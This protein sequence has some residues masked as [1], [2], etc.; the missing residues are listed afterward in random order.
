MD[1][2]ILTICFVSGIVG[3]VIAGFLTAGAISSRKIQEA[4]KA[5]WATACR[6]YEQKRREAGC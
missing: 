3:G 6:H 4:E 2:L 1:L 5:T